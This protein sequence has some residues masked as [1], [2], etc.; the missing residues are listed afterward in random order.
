[1]NRFYE[2]PSTSDDPRR[3][4]RRVQYRVY[5]D[6]WHY[7]GGKR[8][9]P[10]QW[11]SWLSH[12]RPDP[13][14]LAEL[15]T[16][17]IRRQRTLHNAALIE[18]R[19]REERARIAQAN[20]TARLPSPDA[21]ARAPAFESGHTEA[22]SQPSVSTQAASLTTPE[23]PQGNTKDACA[24]STPRS[25]A[26]RFSDLSRPVRDEKWQPQSWSPEAVRR[27]GE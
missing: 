18:A 9:L 20:A 19:D 1:G 24:R 10:V 17:L 2:Y 16:D 8:Q 3:T 27:R 6:M 15:Q 14:T 4:K 21:Q 23:P 12:T 5:D 25:S 22:T 11:V 13:P 7:I 26:G